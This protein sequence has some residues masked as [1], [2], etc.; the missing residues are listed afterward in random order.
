[1]TVLV[2]LLLIAVYAILWLAADNRQLRQERDATDRKIQEIIE[3]L[4]RVKL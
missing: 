2:F 3:R 1:M 4:K